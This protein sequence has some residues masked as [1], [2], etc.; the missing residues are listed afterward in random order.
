[1]EVASRHQFSYRRWKYVGHSVI[2]Y[3]LLFVTIVAS[4]YPSIVNKSTLETIMKVHPNEVCFV[5]SVEMHLL[6]L[7]MGNHFL[8][9]LNIPCESTSQLPTGYA[10]ALHGNPVHGE[11]VSD[12]QNSYFSV[13]IKEPITFVKQ[14]EGL[15]QLTQH[16]S[17]AAWPIV[18]R[19]LARCPESIGN[20]SVPA[21]AS[22]AKVLFSECFTP[23]F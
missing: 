11:S 23:V 16:L 19:R 6:F 10:S 17:N 18:L 15:D 4:L 12:S 5:A 22:G 13:A 9:N 7:C 8:Y 21:H 20:G 14:K 3:N 2:F 1:M